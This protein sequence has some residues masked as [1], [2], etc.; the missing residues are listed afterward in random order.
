MPTAG[1]V[2]RD[3]RTVLANT[4]KAPARTG[5]GKLGAITGDNPVETRG[6]ERCIADRKAARL[7]GARGLY[8]AAKGLV[9]QYAGVSS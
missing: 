7:L 6:E 3:G 1:D 9:A 5:T 2:V 8:S 4:P